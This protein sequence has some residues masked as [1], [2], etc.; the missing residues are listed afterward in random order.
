M[1]LIIDVTLFNLIRSMLIRNNTRLEYKNSSNEN[2]DDIEYCQK[3][4]DGSQN[5]RFCGHITTVNE[6]VVVVNKLALSDIG[7][8]QQQQQSRQNVPNI[9]HICIASTR[10]QS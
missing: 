6:I 5:G 8:Q 10:F 2:A 4:T 7:L 1:Q 3:E 9:D